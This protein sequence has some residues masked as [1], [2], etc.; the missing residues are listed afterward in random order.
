MN[1]C[2]A[3]LDPSLLAQEPPPAVQPGRPPGPL[4]T[5]PS[6]GDRPAADK[7]DA[8]VLPKPGVRLRPLC[9]GEGMPRGAGDCQP[10]LLMGDCAAGRSRKPTPCTW[11]SDGDLQQLDGG[12]IGGGGAGLPPGLADRPRPNTGAV[13]IPGVRLA[14]AFMAALA[15]ACAEDSCF[16]KFPSLS[17]CIA[18]GCGTPW[19]GCV[20]GRCGCCTRGGPPAACDGCDSGGLLWRGDGTNLTA[21]FHPLGEGAL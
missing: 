10:S 18:C 15:M 5:R 7:G 13:E 16:G 11:P 12:T 6:E 20:I 14:V 4:G 21:P 9:L 19:T 8:V 3:G 17:T 1:E 2:G